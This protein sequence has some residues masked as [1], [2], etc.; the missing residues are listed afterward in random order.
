MR[1][2]TRLKAAALIGLAVVVGLLG[3]GGTWALW[4]AAVPSGA[5]T[6]QA[7]N[8]DIRLN[9]D[10]T[11]TT[12]T[13]T[14]ESGALLTPSTPVYARVDVQNASN[15]GTPMTVAAVMSP[16]QVMNASTPALGTN[17]SVRAAST[18]V[19]ESCADASYPASNTSAATTIVQGSTGRFCLRMSLP[20]KAAPTGLTEANAKIATTV[21]VTQQPRGQ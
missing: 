14:P 17:L 16:P 11:A 2:S 18:S 15:A 10:P 12:I 8:F 6:V 5:G 13:A 21:T 7:A 1:I 9:G 19:S 3:V 20:E 4:N